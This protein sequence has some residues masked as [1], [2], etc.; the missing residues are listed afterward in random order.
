MKNI[1]FAIFFALGTSVFA[2]NSEQEYKSAI[3]NSFEKEYKD[4]LVTTEKIIKLAQNYAQDKGIKLESVTLMTR[5]GQTY[6]ALKIST[7]GSSKQNKEA[8]RVAQD[9]SSLPLILSPYD[10]SFGINAFFDPNGS[11]LGVPYQF[12]FED[13]L[14][15]PGYLHE[16]Y[17]ANTYQKAISGQNSFWAGIMSVNKGQY[18]SAE[19]KNAYFRRAAG[20]ELVATALS[21]KLTLERLAY[22]Y[23]TQS[24]KEFNHYSGEASDLLN[25][26]YFEVVTGRYLARQAAD[27]AQ[28]SLTV[29]PTIQE[30]KLSLGDRAY[31]ITETVFKVDSY[32][33][34]IVAG[35][36]T[37]VGLKDDTTFAM[38]SKNPYTP[39]EIRENL[40]RIVAVSRQA[41]VLFKQIE[42]LI[43]VMIE[44]PDIQKTDMK[45]LLAQAQSPFDLL[46]KQ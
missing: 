15:H 28:R 13:G 27:V 36:G 45:T 11:K 41:E 25:E 18:I 44:Y 26:L 40:N 22:L 9:M 5:Q 4:K 29:Q 10:L 34:E 33:W 19:N 3:S 31:D 1:L 14:V 23:K 32:M 38:Y 30:I 12:L 8:A 2:Q 43:Y 24:L 17:H 21:T 37:S 7:V 20:D 6:P 35:K 16:L 42:D 39:Q 46:D